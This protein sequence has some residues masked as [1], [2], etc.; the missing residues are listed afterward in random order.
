MTGKIE[1]GTSVKDLLYDNFEY[2][3]NEDLFNFKLNYRFD[4][5]LEDSLVASLVSRLED[6]FRGDIFNIRTGMSP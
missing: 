6:E 1:F 5:D 2:N 3:L 4:W